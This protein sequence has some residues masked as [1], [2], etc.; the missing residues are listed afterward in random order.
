[1]RSEVRG[2]VGDD[3]GVAL[4]RF[5]SD[6][7]NEW[8]DSE[9]ESLAS[10]ASWINSKVSWPLT[11]IVGQSEYHLP[12]GTDDVDAIVDPVSLTHWGTWVDERRFY[13]AALGD[14]ATPIWTLRGSPIML[15]IKPVPAAVFTVQLELELHPVLPVGDR[16]D[17]HLRPELKDATVYAVS[18]RCHER[19]RD[20][21][22]A[23]KRREIMAA[24][25]DVLR[26]NSGD[27]SN[28]VHVLQIVT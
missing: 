18:A 11:T 25:M 20:F 14:G 2:L 8:L 16:V 28:A 19:E 17:I 4:P 22:M 27:Q 3:E 12:S 26:S 9:L 6:L 7:L 10:T 15:R 5:G 1:M 23:S 24:K 21:D 13:S